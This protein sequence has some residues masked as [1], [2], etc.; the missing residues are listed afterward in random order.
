M[1]G[2]DWSGHRPSRGCTHDNNPKESQGFGS[3]RIGKLLG[4]PKLIRLTVEYMEN[5]ERLRF[6]AYISRKS[7]TCRIIIVSWP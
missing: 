5:T 6:R 2:G 1:P 7:L 4:D 3:M